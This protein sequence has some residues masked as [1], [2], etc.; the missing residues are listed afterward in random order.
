MT[1]G[2][3]RSLTA[4]VAVV[5]CAITLGVST[6]SEAGAPSCKTAKLIVPWKAGGGTHVLFSIYEKTIQGMDFPSKI[7]VV[8]IPGQLPYCVSKGGI[9]QITR[10]MAVELAA[11]GVRVNAIGP[12]SILT[13]MLKTIIT[14]EAA[15]KNILSRTPIGRCGEVAEVA[16]IAVFLASDASSYITGQCLY[17]DGGRLALNGVVPVAD[18]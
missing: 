6:P 16:S 14:D 17:G 13:D 1:K 10:G 11:R 5:A 3:L 2:F 8:T 7:K 12:G 18:D 15:R 4:G 9:N